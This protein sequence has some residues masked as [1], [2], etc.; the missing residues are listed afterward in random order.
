M[1]HETSMLSPGKVLGVFGVLL[2]I[3]V[4]LMMGKRAEFGEPTQ[5]LSAA[6][7]D[8]RGQDTTPPIEQ[9]TE[10]LSVDETKSELLDEEKEEGGEVGHSN[11][12]FNS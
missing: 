11:I 9:S 12:F 6:S 4:A 5:P 10:S 8:S 3:I 7:T 2:L 1:A